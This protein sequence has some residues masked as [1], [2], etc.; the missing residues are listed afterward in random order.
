MTGG[1][2]PQ[3]NQSSPSRVGRRAAE[4]GAA[5]R[6]RRVAGKFERPTGEPEGKSGGFYA[7]G[8]CA[9]DLDSVRERGTERTRGRV[10]YD[11][12]G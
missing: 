7:C 1:F 11:G 9:S 10:V 5:R 6:R 12:P 3:I 8:R 2:W 4:F